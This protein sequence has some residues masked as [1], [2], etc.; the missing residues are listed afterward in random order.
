MADARIRGAG[1]SGYLSLMYLAR[2]STSLSSLL[3][4]IQKSFSAMYCSVLVRGKSIT[5]PG[6]SVSHIAGNTAGWS[7]RERGY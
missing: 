7:G 3:R 6:E 5:R 1:R 4:W 2:N